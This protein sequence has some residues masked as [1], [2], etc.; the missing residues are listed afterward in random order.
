MTDGFYS[1]LS[2]YKIV[3]GNRELM[4]QLINGKALN[5]FY[6]LKELAYADTTFNKYPRLKMIDDATVIVVKNI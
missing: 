4:Y 6:Q 5:L 1:V 2:T 3:Q